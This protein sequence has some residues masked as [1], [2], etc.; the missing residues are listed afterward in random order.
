MDH[1]KRKSKGAFEL[2]ADINEILAEAGIDPIAKAIKRKTARSV[3]EE[4][5]EH[6]DTVLG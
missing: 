6:L 1:L 3:P 4:M 2:Q 5:K